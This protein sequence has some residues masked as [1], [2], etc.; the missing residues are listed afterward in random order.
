VAAAEDRLLDAIDAA[1]GIGNDRAGVHRDP[2]GADPRQHV[3]GTGN[4]V[5]D[6]DNARNLDAVIVREQCGF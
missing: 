6:L 3:G 4:R 2:R 5:A 1:L